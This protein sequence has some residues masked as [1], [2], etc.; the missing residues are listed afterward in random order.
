MPKTERSN[1][2]PPSSPPLPCFSLATTTSAPRPLAPAERDATRATDTLLAADVRWCA[3]AGR[4][5]EAAEDRA[6]AI[7]EGGVVAGRRREGG[8][9]VEGTAGRKFPVAPFSPF[10]SAPEPQGPYI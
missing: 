2:T 3:A 4:T 6:K 7:A 9:E 10:P 8:G 1:L 5:A